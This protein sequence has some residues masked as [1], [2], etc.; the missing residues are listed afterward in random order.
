MVQHVII[1]TGASTGFGG[2]AAHMLA[3]RGHI[4][5]AGARQFEIGATAA[6]EAFARERNVQLHFIMLDITDEQAVN[7]AVQRVIAEQGRID[8]VVHNAGHGT[9]GPSEAFTI[10]QLLRSLD[11]NVVGAQR[12]NQAALPY[13]RKARRGLV[14][15]TSSSSVKGGTP[16]FCGPYFAAKAAMDSLAVIYACELSRWGIESAIIVPGA[17]P[18]GTSHFADMSRPT[19]EAIAAEYLD[20]VYK[21]VP[22]QIVSRLTALFPPEADVSD[23]A[24]AMAHVVELPHGERPFR[25]HVDP[26]NDGCEIVNAVHDRVRSE[27]LWKIGLEDV[28]KPT[29]S[30]SPETHISTL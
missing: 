14:M 9:M 16:P 27:L 11:I 10:Q 20:H 2:I 28:L 24:K 13:M 12:L 4:V 29:N 8:V 21:G 23:V 17:Y 1:I 6:M 18:K 7:S 25:T 26:S 30:D 22:E 5:Y 15:W 19:N 3:V